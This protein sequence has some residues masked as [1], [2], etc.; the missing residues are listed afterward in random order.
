[1]WLVA[2]RIG[3]FLTEAAML[4]MFGRSPAGLARAAFRGPWRVLLLLLIVAFL[5][6]CIAGA[7][8]YRTAYRDRIEQAN[9]AIDYKLKQLQAHLRQSRQA[10]PESGINQLA[11][12]WQ[13]LVAAAPSDT[14]VL[15]D[16]TGNIMLIQPEQGV[17]GMSDVPRDAATSPTTITDLLPADETRLA[18]L[19]AGIQPIVF[20]ANNSRHF[21]AASRDDSGDLLVWAIGDGEQLIAQTRLSALNAATAQTAFTLMLLGSAMIVVF[22]TFIHTE[23]R[24]A[25]LVSDLE[26]SEARLHESQA[27]ANLGDWWFDMETGKMRW[28]RRT[29]HIF[30]VDPETFTP[31]VEGVFERIHP[32][33]VEPMRAMT[34]SIAE[35]RD[36]T[37]L[38]FRIIRPDGEVRHLRSTSENEYDVQGNIIARKGTVQDVTDIQTV[39]QILR[40][41]VEGTSRH[42]GDDY[43]AALSRQLA[44]T[45]NVAMVVIGEFDASAE[46]ACNVLAGWEGSGPTTIR[47]YTLKHTPCELVQSRDCVYYADHVAEAFPNDARLRD[48]SMRSYLAVPLVTIHGVHVGQLAVLDRK[49]MP[50]REPAESIIRIFA[51]R[52]GAELERLNAERQLRSNQQRLELLN[53]ISHCINVGDDIR[54]ITQQT[55]DEMARVFPGMRVTFCSVAPAGE[56]VTRNFSRASDAGP[57]TSPPLVRQVPPDALDM[58]RNQH[59]VAVHD[60]DDVEGFGDLT[61][62]DVYAWMAAPLV[63]GGRL[64]GLLMVD[65]QAVHNWTDHEQRLTR[66]VAQLLGVAVHQDEVEHERDR[67]VGALQRG[68]TFLDLAQQIAHVGSWNWDVQADRVTWS[69]EMYR[70]FGVNNAQRGIHF[71]NLMSMVHPDD[72]VRLAELRERSSNDG[73]SEPI[74]YRIIRPDGSER[75]IRAE[76]RYFRDDSGRV[77][78]VI[79]TVQDVTTQKQQERHRKLL[80]D[81]LDHRVKNTLAAIVSLAEQTAHMSSDLDEFQQAFIGRL[82]AM[83]HTHEALAKRRWEHVNLNEMIERVLSAHLT[84]NEPRVRIHCGDRLLPSRAAMPLSLALHELATNAVKYGALS[85]T[86]GWVELRTD[87][88]SDHPGLRII[89]QEHNGPTVVEPNRKGLGMDLISG[90]VNYELAGSVELRFDPDGVICVLRLPVEAL[91][92]QTLQFTESV[93][94]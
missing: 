45:L 5:L 23:R 19:Q 11:E 91:N 85:V 72:R 22:I 59:V 20:F 64:I 52:A 25:A 88:T 67:A 94:S 73:S 3:S 76:N 12:S 34:R 40:R 57:G 58:L 4:P 66:E 2:L 31:T 81:E 90:L 18:E 29:F 82:R 49:P 9:L 87:E 68:K 28:S 38:S 78:R 71:A 13:A 62:S 35:R 63:E 53:H 44:N 1:V 75:T 79:G 51:A 84:G 39:E 65:A 6:S 30:G 42:V 26:A 69:D 32:D 56:V 60:A 8:T 37:S 80:T 47:R 14:Y 48:A 50:A 83:A 33:D 7:Y 70:I 10:R 43:F 27:I 92:L 54:Q 21:V 41:L 86:D 36:A 89:W 46:P 74:E 93:R 77:S 16:L 24:V 61:E 15:T 55:V 17:A